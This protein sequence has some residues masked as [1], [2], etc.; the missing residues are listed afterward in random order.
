M[1]RPMILA[2]FLAS[3][4]VAGMLSNAVRSIDP[5]DVRA[6]VGAF[7]TYVVVTVALWFLADLFELKFT[8]EGPRRPR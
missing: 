1:I 4:V 5:G 2:R 7:C 8:T 6:N 3:C